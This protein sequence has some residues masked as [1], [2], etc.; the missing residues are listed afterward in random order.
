SVTCESL[1]KAAAQVVPQLMPD[2]FD[3]T[4]PLPSPGRRTASVNITT[5][6]A[7]SGMSE[8]SGASPGAQPHQVR[9][10]IDERIVAIDEEHP[11]RCEHQQHRRSGD[12]ES[13]QALHTVAQAE[14]EEH[15][16]ERQA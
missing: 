1:T 7:M 11:R 9:P 14:P 6:A 13:D 15:G 10:E 3:V 2:R 8:R 5:L 4:V 12:G 16:G